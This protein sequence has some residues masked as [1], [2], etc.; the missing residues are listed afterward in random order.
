MVFSFSVLK[1]EHFRCSY[2]GVVSNWSCVKV[3]H[4]VAL[5][6]RSRLHFVRLAYELRVTSGRQ[7]EKKWLDVQNTLNDSQILQQLPE[8]CHG[9]W[10]PKTPRLF[11]P[12]LPPSNE[13]SVSL[14]H[15]IP[16]N[17][18]KMFWEAINHSTIWTWDVFLQFRAVVKVFSVQISGQFHKLGNFL[19][20]GCTVPAWSLDFVGHHCAQARWWV[21][22][23]E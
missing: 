22:D 13:K 18:G 23:I 11:L 19:A 2:L 7:A 14:C 5:N 16:H 10:A 15:D 21:W 20:A 3:S 1:H 6:I 4:L 8:T 17:E 12:T 9:P